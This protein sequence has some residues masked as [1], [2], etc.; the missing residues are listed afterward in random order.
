M[1]FV[2]D[3][4]DAGSLAFGFLDPAQVIRLIPCFS[5]DLT[6]DFLEPS[7]AQLPDEGDLDWRCY[8]VNM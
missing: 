4:P 1:G 3:S 2:P 8:F 6:G 5:E 7:L